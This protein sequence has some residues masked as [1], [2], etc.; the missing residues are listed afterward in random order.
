[1]RDEVYKWLEENHLEL[2]KLVVKWRLPPMS[3]IEAAE[4]EYDKIV[5]HGEKVRKILFGWRI[6]ALA[7]AI[8]RRDD[9]EEIKNLES[10]QRTIVE[11]K[12]D[13]RL[14]QNTIDALIEDIEFL[15]RPWI[16]KQFD[17]IRGWFK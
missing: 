8:A 3:I 1:M 11:L 2:E 16:K 9:I 14:L 7:K 15:K 13:K 12:N 10:A 17:K 5:K 6:K 4:S